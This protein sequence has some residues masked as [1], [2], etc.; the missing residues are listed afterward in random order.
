MVREVAMDFGVL[1]SLFWLEETHRS[2][3]VLVNSSWSW[4]GVSWYCWAV[5]CLEMARRAIFFSYCK[6][7]LRQTVK[8]GSENG[9]TASSRERIL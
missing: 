2:Q 6:A 7:L 9:G 4:S 1:V 3:V 8:S 5:V